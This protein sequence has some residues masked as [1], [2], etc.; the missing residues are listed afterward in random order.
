VYTVVGDDRGTDI[1]E[2]WNPH[3]QMFTPKG[4]PGLENGYPTDHDR[5]KLPLAD[6]CKFYTGFT[7]E[8]GTPAKEPA[9][10]TASAS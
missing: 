7:F 6:A 1:V 8:T 10:G 2:I 5:F 4:T 9:A 3:G